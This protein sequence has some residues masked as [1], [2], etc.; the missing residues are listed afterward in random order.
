LDTLGDTVVLDEP[1]GRADLTA[2]PDRRFRRRRPL[3]ASEVCDNIEAFADAMRTSVRTR[4]VGV[5][6]RAGRKGEVRIDKQLSANF[7]LVIN[8]HAAFVGVLDELITRASVHA[9][10]RN[11]LATLM[12]W[13]G[14]PF[15]V[16]RGHSTLGELFH[17]PLALEL[18]AIPDRLDRQLHLLSWFF[19]RIIEFLPARSI[20]R[21][22]DIMATGGAALTSISPTAAT[23]PPPRERRTQPRATNSSLVRALGE[24]L[25]AH[26]GR[27]WQ[28]YSR[29]SVRRALAAP[30][31]VLGHR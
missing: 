22:E 15:P 13:Q 18:A 16:A 8:H 29:D 17:P 11:P 6:K 21:F 10:V 23:V 14:V 27:Y 30:E 3:T 9:I 2:P 31:S 4:G 5:S 25:L 19:G 20:L 28:L 7:L 12:S 1:M 24:R 26:D